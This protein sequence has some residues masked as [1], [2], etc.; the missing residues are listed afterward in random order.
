MMTMADPAPFILLLHMRKHPISV[1][2]KRTLM[3]R[4]CT[5]SA[6]QFLVAL[7]AIASFLIPLKAQSTLL[8]ITAVTH[9]QVGYK[10]DCSTHFGGTMAGTGISSLLG[11][12]SISGND[13][14]TPINDHFSF[15]GELTITTRNGDELFADYSGLFRPTVYLPLFTLKDAIF[16]IT[17]GTGSFS[18]ATG[19]G[20]LMGG[21]NIL[22]GLGLIQARGQI[23]DFRNGTVSEDLPSPLPQNEAPEPGILALLGIG[24]AG[25]W[26]HRKRVN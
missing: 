19:G 11:L 2:L 23:F 15:E 26:M 7:L 6:K 24:L 5:D 4:T 20:V 14:I 3:N 25:L 21:Q 8:T 10:G 1:P 17:G 22:T 9:E 12:V 16:E 18:Q 13:C